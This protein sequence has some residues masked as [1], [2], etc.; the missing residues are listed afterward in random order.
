MSKELKPYEK[1]NIVIRKLRE[2]KNS[3]Q[4]LITQKNATEKGLERYKKTY[5]R[6]IKAYTENLEKTRENLEIL[7]QKIKNY[8]EQ[9]KDFLPKP[10]IIVTDSKSVKVA[11]KYC[12]KEYSKSGIK[13][14]Q[15]ACLKKIELAK[16]Q[17]EI[18]K[19]EL[20]DALEELDKE[21]QAEIIEDVEEIIEDLEDSID[22]DQLTE[23]VS[24]IVTKTN[25]KIAEIL[26]KEKEKEGD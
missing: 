17:K 7:D 20:E 3:K 6:D 18:D 15:K 14:H 1:E 19:L 13:S 21:E 11:C 8:I 25:D 4:Y 23:D 5:E 16:L 26:D 10:K 24:F 9:L 12:K 2:C 22:L